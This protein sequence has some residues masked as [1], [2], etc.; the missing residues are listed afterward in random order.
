ME[1]NHL[2]DKPIREACYQM[3]FP[4]SLSAD[5]HKK[6]RRT[7]MDEGFTPFRLDDMDQEK[8]YYGPNHRVSHRDMER[9]YLPFT[10]HV[11]FPHEHHPEGFQRMSKRLDIRAVLHMRHFEAPFDLYSVDVVLCPFDTGFITLRV[12]LVKA[13]PTFTEA[14]AFAERL[15]VLQDAH[16]EDHDA[17]VA[18]EGETYEEVQDFIFKAIVPHTVQYLDRTPMDGA[19]FEKLPY[20]IDERMYV[21]AY[22]GLPEDAEITLTDRYRA[23][24]LDGMDEDGLP[25]ISASH[26]PYIEQYC[27]DTGFDRWAPNTYYLTDESCFCCLTRL[28]GA[29]AARVANKMYGEYYYGLLLNLFHRIVLLKLSNAYSRVRLERTPEQ[30]EVLIRAIT[31]FSAKYDFLEVVSQSQGREIFVQIRRM[32]GN[33]ELFDDVKMTLTDL[34]KYQ[35]N[36]TSKRSSYLLTVLTIYT[37]ISGIYGMNQVIDDLEG[38]IRW[39][40]MNGYSPFQWLA[41]IVIMSGL[42]VAFLLSANILWKWGRDLIKRLRA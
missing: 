29:Q 36:A 19:Y 33:D 39:G 8:A 6:M 26:P 30:T 14:I 3:L 12:G 4:F 22:Y 17:W 38:P 34:Y 2:K 10:N 35:E 37:V 16:A 9:Y 11:L 7:L 20:L 31:T 1:L 28:P 25:Y 40:N 42:V 18:Y 23:A 27:R 21:I 5:C 24:R 32:Y 13:S 41:L 15:R